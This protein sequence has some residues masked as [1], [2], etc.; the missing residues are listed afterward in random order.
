M[1][2]LIISAILGV[3]MMF[4]GIVLKEKRI[5]RNIAIAGI[6][7]VFAVNIFEFAGVSFFQIDTK[8]MMVFDRF[9]LLFNSIAFG[10]TMIYFL[11]SARDIEKVGANYAD[12]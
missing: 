8:G 9:A 1:N 7:F 2:A 12:Y 10:C 5:V 6:L 11:L 3:I 4:S